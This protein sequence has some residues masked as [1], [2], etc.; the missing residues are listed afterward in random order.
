ML[1]SMLGIQL[2]NGLLMLVV[3][4]ITEHLFSAHAC[5][6]SFPTHGF[7]LS[8]VINAG[9]SQFPDCFHVSA[10]KIV[11]FIFALIL[12]N[13]LKNLDI[14]NNFFTNCG[15]ISKNNTLTWTLKQ[16]ET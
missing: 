2:R 6:I 12:N 4:M 15:P 8:I 1:L 13:S 10:I 5:L 9:G 14:N 16:I 11:Y 3:S 7:W